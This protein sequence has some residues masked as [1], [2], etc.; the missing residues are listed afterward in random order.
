VVGGVE[1][2]VLAHDRKAD[3]TEVSTV[4]EGMSAV[5]LVW[6]CLDDVWW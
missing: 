3:E 6:D 5:V 1:N 4:K 2:E